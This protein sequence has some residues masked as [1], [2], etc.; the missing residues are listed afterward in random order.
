M[1]IRLA[2]TMLGLSQPKIGEAKNPAAC[3]GALKGKSLKNEAELVLVLQLDL[4]LHRI[5]YNVAHK[6]LFNLADPQ[7]NSIP[8]GLPRCCVGRRSAGVKFQHRRQAPTVR[9][10]SD[11]TVRR[12]ACSLLISAREEQDPPMGRTCWGTQTSPG[13]ICATPFGI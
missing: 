9:T 4:S 12:T 2:E 11:G 1:C 10:C 3:C 8:P 6:V 13:R 7:R 5:R